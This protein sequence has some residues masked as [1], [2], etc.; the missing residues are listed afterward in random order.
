MFKTLLTLIASKARL[1]IEY[2]IVA[3]VI[4][5]GCTAVALYW[6][7]KALEANAAKLTSDVSTLQANAKQAGADNAAQQQAINDLITQRAQDAFAMQALS[8]KFEAFA[9]SDAQTRSKL[10][11]L[12]KNNAQVRDH[13]S[14]PLPPDLQRLFNGA[15][16]DA[17]PA[18]GDAGNK[19]NAPADTPAGVQSPQAADTR[20][21][22]RSGGRLASVAIGC[23]QLCG[24]H[25]CGYRLV[26]A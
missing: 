12:V 4:A 8:A 13:R 26:R 9:Q 17:A 10:N 19:G 14:Q 1:Y 15:D 2:A 3:A 25:G 11:D 24:P 20:Y 16:G 22:W 23:A 21:E 18:N 7:G 6:R 5:L